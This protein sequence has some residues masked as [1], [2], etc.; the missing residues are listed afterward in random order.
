M[1]TPLTLPCAGG[2][3]VGEFHNSN[4][5]PSNNLK[6]EEPVQQEKEMGQGPNELKNE[7]KEPKEKGGWEQLHQEGEIPRMQ[8]ATVQNSAGGAASA[9]SRKQE[10]ER[11]GSVFPPRNGS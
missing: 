8:G 7:P 1:E 10:P 9:G 2:L 4:S 5:A 11:K 3:A 6:N